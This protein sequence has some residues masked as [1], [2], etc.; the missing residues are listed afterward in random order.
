MA[1][2][3]LVERVLTYDQGLFDA[4]LGGDRSLMPDFV[5]PMVLVKNA[6]RRHFGEMFV[7]RYYHETEGWKGFSSYALGDEFPASAR[8]RAGREKAEEIIP[9]RSLS[10]LRRLRRTVA[11]RRFG[12]GTPDL[13]LYDDTGRFKFVEVKKTNNDPVRPSQLRCIAQIIKA[14]CCEVDI[15]RLRQADQSCPARTYI[16][17]LERCRGW[18]QSSNYALQRPGVRAARPG[19]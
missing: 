12:G 15:V 8:R 2:K 3:E 19:H 6:P 17:D 4:W 16:L 14:L 18:R 7:L 10:R 1:M 5:D 11:D 13:F 9:G